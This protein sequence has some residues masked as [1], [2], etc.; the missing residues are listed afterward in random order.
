MRVSTLI[1]S[2]SWLTS[3]WWNRIWA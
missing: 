2:F 3:R 1:Q